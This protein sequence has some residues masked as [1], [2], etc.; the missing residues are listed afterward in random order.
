MCKW[1]KVK[2]DAAE[3]PGAGTRRKERV[4]TGLRP[5]PIETKAVNRIYRRHCANEGD[6]LRGQSVWGNR[7]GLLSQQ[8]QPSSRITKAGRDSCAGLPAQL[9]N[10]RTKINVKKTNGNVDIAL[11]A[12]GSPSQEGLPHFPIRG[13]RKRLHRSQ[14]GANTGPVV[15]KWVNSRVRDWSP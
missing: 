7:K 1:E 12:R 8:S 9:E 4:W 2:L 15:E 5:F 13:S 6:K 14:L 3:L 10:K 11:G